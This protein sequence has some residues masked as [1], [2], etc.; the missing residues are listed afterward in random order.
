MYPTQATKITKT[1]E[2]TTTTLTINPGAIPNMME[3]VMDDTTKVMTENPAGAKINLFAALFGKL[4]QPPKSSCNNNDIVESSLP[5]TS[6]ND[7]NNVIRDL[8][9][10]M[11]EDDTEPPC[12][13]D[14]L[15]SPT[16]EFE[17]I[18]LSPMQL[19]DKKLFATPTQNEN[20]NKSCTN[21]KEN[22]SGLFTF[23]QSNQQSINFLKTSSKTPPIQRR[24][25]PQQQA[26]PETVSKPL[27]TPE[28]KEQEAASLPSSL[29][30]D[31]ESDAVKSAV[32]ETPDNALKE[33]SD[34]MM[35]TSMKDKM[36]N[37]VKAVDRPDLEQDEKIS[38]PDDAMTTEQINESEQV[39]APLKSTGP[40][41]DG[42]AVIQV[43]TDNDRHLTAELTGDSPIGKN[44]TKEVV[45]HAQKAELMREQLDALFDDIQAAADDLKHGNPWIA[46]TPQV[47][48]EN[49]NRLGTVLQN[50]SPAGSDFQNMI[51]AATSA[52]TPIV[53]GGD[54][55]GNLYDRNDS[56]LRIRDDDDDDDSV[57]SI[58]SC[59]ETPV[60]S[61][62]TYVQ[63]EAHEEEM[64]FVQDDPVC[65][66]TP[67]PSSTPLPKSKS[68]ASIASSDS[69]S[70][71]AALA[72]QSNTPRTRKILEWLDP[73][74]RSNSN[75]SDTWPAPSMVTNI[76]STNTPERQLRNRQLNKNESNRPPRKK[77]SDWWIPRPSQP[78]SNSSSPMSLPSMLGTCSVNEVSDLESPRLSY[79]V[80][81]Y[82]FSEEESDIH[83]QSL[84]D[85]AS[86][87]NSN[88]E[89]SPSLQSMLH[90]TY[91]IDGKEINE[92]ST[93]KKS[94]STSRGLNYEEQ[95]CD[96]SGLDIESRQ[97]IVPNS[98]EQTHPS[99][100]HTPMNKSLDEFSHTS[101]W[102]RR[103]SVFFIVLALT[104]TIA[105]PL[106]LRFLAPK[107]QDESSH[108]ITPPQDPLPL[109][110]QSPSAAPVTWPTSTPA[111]DNVSGT[112]AEPTSFGSG[113]EEPENSWDDF[114]WNRIEMGEDLWRSDLEDG[115]PI[116]YFAL[117]V[118]D[119]S[120]K[121]S[122]L[123]LDII[124][125]ADGVYRSYI[126]RA[127]DD[128]RESSAVVA[129]NLSTVPYQS[130]CEPIPG[131]IKICNGTFGNTDWYGQTILLMRDNAIVAA[132][133]QINTSKELSSDILQHTLCHQLGHAL[134]L[135]HNDKA[136]CLQDIGGAVVDET[137]I[138]NQLQHPSQED[139]DSLVDLY[140][141]ASLR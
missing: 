20:T 99:P 2:K 138:S 55:S 10:D 7:D 115:S 15:Q 27:E 4:P 96:D 40:T 132:A 139:L 1:N 84:Q 44:D 61:N 58:D 35:A 73:K 47:K 64:V 46:T 90:N 57:P 76:R 72:I 18:P 126:T 12:T 85:Q 38:N 30:S 127:V 118:G 88:G 33:I 82:K 103:C 116:W 54:N 52:P 117:S 130:L 106:C 21:S 69:E 31:R 111:E 16:I 25:R 13:S 68:S 14:L 28:I 51:S 42:N 136:S 66:P 105:V 112:T 5:S 3:E 36:D 113:S 95:G 124:N 119:E 71:V 53:E 43:K 80:L 81:N 122:G 59:K 79:H 75:V 74:S 26:K 97:E 45:D 11:E 39:T 22:Y 29:S 23:F 77:V 78:S 91:N 109:F 67:Q 100:T 48:K 93:S 120:G 83:S 32:T 8:K 102:L 89:I 101:W 137:A 50:V 135:P 63:L 140:G 70:N 107:Q 128:Y 129:L 131:K 125:A 87:I 9:N 37:V 134:G 114:R 98:T 60:R 104:A 41:E 94:V 92:P 17:F 6:A 24:Q 123:D 110:T 133:I 62:L 121:S 108:I 19:N 34:S 49:R 86:D 65:Q 141:S 56:P